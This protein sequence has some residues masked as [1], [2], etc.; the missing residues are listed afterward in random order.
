VVQDDKS[1]TN[2]L[3]LGSTE[4][5]TRF[6]DISKLLLLLTFSPSYFFVVWCSIE[7]TL[8]LEKTRNSFI[9]R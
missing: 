9:L 1:N 4:F 3:Y 5:C 6:V 2:L 7:T 8:E